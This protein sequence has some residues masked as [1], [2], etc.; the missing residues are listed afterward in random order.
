[1]I[2]FALV[3][4]FVF[5]LLDR[6]L[7]YCYRGLFKKCGSN[8]KFFPLRSD[9]FYKNITIDNNV[10][11]GPGASF[12]LSRSSLRIMNNSFFGP[13]VTIRGGNHSSHIVGKFMIDYK[14]MDK[15]DCDDED[16]LIEEDVWVGTGAI[17]LKGVTVGRGSIIA[18]GS[19][20]TKDVLPYSIVGGV[21]SKLIKFRWDVSTI[22]DHELLLYP[23]SY[24]L[25]IDKY[26]NRIKN[27]GKK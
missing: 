22:K 15:L 3:H 6:L 20:V 10:Y 9:F 2:V 27:L 26:T 14:D 7:M 23:E 19:V 18:A 4:I 5:K 24:R 1:M 16:V 17:I 25:D 11:I 12:L 21:P 8:V 13:N